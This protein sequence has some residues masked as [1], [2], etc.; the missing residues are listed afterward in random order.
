MS[1]AASKCLSNPLDGSSGL[2]VVHIISAVALCNGRPKGGAPRR[3][4]AVGSCR[5]RRGERA[6]LVAKGQKVTYPLLHRLTISEDGV[7]V[8]KP[9]HVLVEKDNGVSDIVS[10]VTSVL[11]KPV[12]I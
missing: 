3:L 1:K 7:G 9:I 4:N 12:N 5:R 11:D 10:D 2:I 8:E 6:L